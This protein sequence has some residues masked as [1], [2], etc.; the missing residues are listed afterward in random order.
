MFTTA[1]LDNLKRRWASRPENEWPLVVR[2]GL[3]D[4]RDDDRERI[5]HYVREL[6]SADQSKITRHIRGAADR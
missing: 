6:D 2:I 5:E 1:Y 3:Q 4:H